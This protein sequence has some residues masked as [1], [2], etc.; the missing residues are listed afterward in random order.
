MNRDFIGP[1]VEP[2]IVV[3]PNHKYENYPLNI[4]VYDYRLVLLSTLV[5]EV[6][7]NREW[8]SIER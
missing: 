1:R 6:S 7:F 2:V 8:K 5:K 4:S 3:L